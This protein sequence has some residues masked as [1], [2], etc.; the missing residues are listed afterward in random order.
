[1]AIRDLNTADGNE[2]A[3]SISADG[4]MMLLFYNGDIYYSEKIIGGWSGKKIFPSINL[5]D[6]W[7]ADASITAD[8]NAVIFTSDRK[9]GIG[10][11]HPFSTSYHGGYSGNTDI[12]ISVKTETGWSKPFNIGTDI[13]TPFAERTPFLHPDMKTLYFS[14]EGHNSIGKLDVYKSTRLNENSWT[15]WS[16]PV[17][18]GKE[19]NSPNKEWGYKISTDG[20]IAYYTNFHDGE[21]DINFIELPKELQPEIVITISGTVTDKNTKKTLKANIIWED[22]QTNKK[23]GQLQSDPNTGKYIITLPMGKNYGFY[24]EKNEYYPLSG[25]IDLTKKEQS[26]NI[27][28]HFQL[29]TIESIIN[30]QVA[31]PLKNVFFDYDKYSLKPESF[32]ELNRFANFLKKNPNLKIE[33]SGHTDDKGADDYNNNL[34]G[35]RAKSVKKYLVSQGCNENMLSA[36]GYGKFKPIADNSTEAGRAK[37][38]RVEFKV[39]KN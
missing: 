27:V 36:K 14:S 29:I 30:E 39:L 21:S 2:A 5:E 9:G 11:H 24:V 7:E 1:M 12:Y 23:V 13:N 25:N 6:D 10:L 33:I 15:E 26:E 35:N 16:E 18:L 34:S 32:P 3:L 8:G 28:K 19:I 4:N 37:N 22:L 31:I 38:R 17:N 20:K